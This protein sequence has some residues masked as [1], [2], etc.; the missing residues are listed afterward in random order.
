[1]ENRPMEQP[2]FT[3]PEEEIAFLRAQLSEKERAAEVPLSPESREQAAEEVVRAYEH[4][5]KDKVLAPEYAEQ[6][7]SVDAIVLELTP[8][9]DDTT[10]NELLGLMHEKG[11]KNT[12]AIV[13]RMN[14]PHIADDFHRF[15]VQYIAHAAEVPELKRDKRLSQAL[16]M[17]LYAVS[18]PDYHGEEGGKSF[19]EII[20]AMEQFYAG[21]MS[22]SENQNPVPGKDFFSL[23][24]AQADS[25]SDIVFYVAVPRNKATMFEKHME[26]V[27]PKVR[28]EEEKDDY[29]IFNES[30]AVAGAF[31]V[32]SK[33][34]LLPLR[35][36][37]TFDQ[38]PLDVVLNAF[39]KIKKDGEGLAV[40]MI[41]SPAGNHFLKRYGTALEQL[42]KG[43]KTKKALDV[44]RTVSGD[45]TKGF[46][47]IVFG[48]G[49][50]KKDTQ[51]IP[52]TPKLDE[53]AIQGVTTKLT[54][55]IFDTNI[56][57]IASAET[58]LRAQELLRDVSSAFNQFSNSEGNGILFKEMSGRALNAFVKAYT[59]RTFDV[60]ESLPLNLKE[61]T[62]L[63]HMP[64][65]QEDAAIL[66]KAKSGTA[67]APLEIGG[68]EGI[69]L[70]VNEY[71]GATTDI[72]MAPE[73]RLR[74]F[75]VIGQ[76]GTGKTTMLKN[77][78]VQDIQQGEG[79]CMIDPHGSDIQDI[80]NQIPP[81]RAEDVIYFDPAHTARPMGLNMLEYDPAFPEQK[82]FVVDE[83]LS[84]FNKLFDMKVAGG[85][86][87]EQYFRN[88]TML[89]MDNPETGNT[90]LDVS[91]VLA[92]ARFRALKLSRCKNP[93]IVQ[94][95]Q[96]IAS[97]A[98]G[99]SSLANIVP[100]ITNKFDIFLSNEIMRPIVAQEKSAFN[101]RDVMD[102]KKIL[103]IN[104]S[105]G[106]LGDINANLLGL[107]IVGKILMAALSRVDTLGKGD[108]APFYLYIDEFQN[109]TTDSIA[110]I[111]SE[112]RKYKLSLT[113]AHQFI[114]QLDESI[115]DAVF[116]NVGSMAV[117][118]V[119][120]EDAEFFEKQFAPTFS[121]ADIMNIDNYNA[122]VR[123]LVKGQPVKP[124]NIQ[125][126]APPEGGYGIGEKIKELSYLR[127]GRD[128]AE[129]EEEIMQKYRKED[130][131]REVPE[132]KLYN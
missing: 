128:R 79:V 32:A 62:S 1:M 86:M 10:M 130:L 25:R 131:Q 40:Q 129:V 74:H 113:I 121:A 96:D 53:Q 22:V 84:I 14:N 118:R 15:L 19:K 78:I 43:M 54:S 2:K 24:I 92:D 33:S 30:G 50:P 90:L 23:E 109:V 107:I 83:L 87:F 108:L 66:R 46:G 47:D 70:G 104:L 73:D 132:R 11:L 103:L 20:S 56:R 64:A 60:V 45:I 48:T 35:T 49:L 16:H 51:G 21:M 5:P 116:G 77:M 95:W 4:A 126:M 42:R 38:D 37:D 98:G 7:E 36:Y 93:L 88:A 110:T 44:P 80:L 127:Y 69:L 125:A 81:E 99:E 97:K 100:Y 112:A 12:L 114:A 75:Y 3:S 18:L 26:A 85:P 76:T 119:G 89:V 9:K 106:R 34:P 67:S 13:E 102:N 28:I 39:S 124:F 41:V 29:N 61:M 65:V 91:R 59:Y 122:Y 55:T 101:F 31:G 115:R 72:H 17:K 52:E 57:V 120:T 68:N 105:K 8:D 58:M 27:F 6:E 117:Y 71:R 94:F 123:V 63:M 82:T 111:L